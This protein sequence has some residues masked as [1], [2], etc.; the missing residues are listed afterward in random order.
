MR[1]KNIAILGFGALGASFGKQLFNAYGDNFKVIADGKRQY[2]IVEKG[3]SVNG[4]HFF[5]KTVNNSVKNYKID[6]LIIAVKNNQLKESLNDIKNIVDDNTI[7]L[8]LLNGISAR[9]TIL[10]TFPKCKVLYG[11]SFIAAVRDVKNYSIISSSGKIEF[12]Y[13]NNKNICS[14]VLEVK[15]ILDKA[16]IRNKICDDMLRSMWKKFMINIG[17]N[18]LSAITESI[19]EQMRSI[20]EQYNLI[21]LAMLETVKV[22]KAYNIDL[23]EQDV[24]DF[25]RVIDATDGNSKTSM[26]QDIE[27]RQKTEVEYFSGILIKKARDKNIDVPVNEVLNKLI[28]SK[29]KMYLK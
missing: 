15:E 22:A 3:V 1:I 8:P 27:N 10:E 5:P 24:K 18:Q 23:R 21:E 13:A 19:Y 14:E 4:E 28:I 26:L 12:G 9:D 2:K 17:I 16:G 11:L 7:I 6:L 20:P 25:R 29:E